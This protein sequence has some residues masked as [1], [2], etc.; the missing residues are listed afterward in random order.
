MTA[1]FYADDR[2]RAQVGFREFVNAARF[3][4]DGRTDLQWRKRQV[5]TGARIRYFGG[6]FWNKE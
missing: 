1:V 3:N 6:V 4:G 5:D 2:H